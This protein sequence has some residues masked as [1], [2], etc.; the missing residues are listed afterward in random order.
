MEELKSGHGIEKLD[1]VCILSTT[2]Q[3]R[4]TDEDER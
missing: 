4:N 3:A 1:I 2:D